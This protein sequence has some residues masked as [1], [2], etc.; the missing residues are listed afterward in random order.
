MGYRNDSPK[1]AN[2]YLGGMANDMA[3]GAGHMFFVNGIDGVGDNA[4]TG[5]TPTEPLLTITYA[6]SLC[7]NDHDDYIVVLD[8]WQ[9]TGEVFPINV[10][11]SKVH[12]IGVPGAGAQWPTIVP[13]GATAAFDAS[14]AYIEIAHFALQAGATSGCIE[15]TVTGKWGILIRDCWFGV[16]GAG[17]D[18]FRGVA[19]FDLP[20]LT[21]TGCR[22]GAG[23][24]RDGVRLDHNATRGK[25]GLPHGAGNLFDRVGGVGINLTGN[26]SEVGSFNNIFA[27]ATDLAGGAITYSAGCADCIANGNSA[28]FGEAVANNPYT[29]G[30]GVSANQ[31]LLNYHGNTMTLPA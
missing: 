26:C 12:I 20:Y 22:F 23:L 30:A 16:T 19:P 25:I 9:P 10:N 6:L 2:W 4:N 29:D 13:T 7:A 8:H 15:S 3:P 21:I 1:Q 31:W 5:L 17:Q 28:N 27:M 14:A 11:K 18:G 24:T